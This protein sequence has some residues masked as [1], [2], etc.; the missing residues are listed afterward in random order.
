MH[1]SL[2]ILA[3]GASSRMKKQ[4]SLENLSEEEIQQANERS[5]G[6]IGVGPNGRPLLDYLLLNTKKY[7]SSLVKKINYSKNFMAVKIKIM[8]FMD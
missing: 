7:T 6:L 1:N 3:G 5:K 4:A 8:I 2:I